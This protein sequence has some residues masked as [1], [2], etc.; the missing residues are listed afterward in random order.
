LSRC[1]LDII[2]LAGFDYSFDSLNNDDEPMAR[3]YQ[4]LMG[5]ERPSLTF[6]ALSFLSELCR[7]LEFLRDNHSVM[8]NIKKNRKTVEEI[9]EKLL[10]TK[11][12]ELSLLQSQGQNTTKKD[13]LSILIRD[14]LGL[15]EPLSDKE[16]MDQCLTFLAAGHETTSSSLS[17]TLLRLA[18]DQ[19]VQQ[20]LRAE[21]QEI[22]P[23]ER[24]LTYDELNNTL[25]YLNAVCK[26]VLRVDSPVQITVR[27]AAKDDELCGYKVPK[28]TKIIIPP[29]VVH[30]HPDI[31]G[32]D[33]DKFLPERFT[34]QG[35]L[36][37]QAKGPYANL[38]FIAG[39]R[40]CIGHRFALTE[41]KAILVSLIRNFSFEEDEPGKYI[42][43]TSM[44]VMRPKGNELFMKVK[45][46]Q[47]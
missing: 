39:P 18:Q 26:E 5:V 47:K 23:V 19:R 38:T 36:P 7:P 17:W 16:I 44:I 35:K 21:I 41:M 2:G 32:P 4:S 25:P 8:K 34:E 46:M 45:R 31:W 22:Y 40:N 30:F 20:K 42:N 9:T 3:A 28:G 27:E 10:Q 14:N 11:K 29:T 15:D 13:I 12:A 43:R 33:A 1:T 24:T 6:F 37:E